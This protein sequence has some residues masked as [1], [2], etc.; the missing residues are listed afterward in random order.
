M[1]VIVLV[2]IVVIVVLGWLLLSQR[3]QAPKI[4]PSARRILFPFVGDALSER[5]LDATLRLARSEGATVVPAYLAEVPRNLPLAASLPRKSGDAI[6]CLEAVEQRAGQQG[7]PVDSRIERGRTF[8]HAMRELM[9]H[10]D[11][12][13]IVVAAATNGSDGLSPADI[14][15]LLANAPGE[16]IVLRPPLKTT[17]PRRLREDHGSAP[18]HARRA[19]LGSPPRLRERGNPQKPAVT[20]LDR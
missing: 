2:A 12:D 7:I 19:E 11:F 1:I 14:A 6:P 5:A 18:R 3:R 20:N 16:I 15:W 17:F 10:E 9:E 8:R 13:Q 4:T